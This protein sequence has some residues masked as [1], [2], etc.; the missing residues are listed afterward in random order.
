MK[1]IDV[2][3]KYVSYEIGRDI[4]SPFYATDGS[5]GMDLAACIKEPILLKPSQKETIPTGIAIQLP[6]N[7]YVALIFGRSG[8]GI[9]HGITLSNSVGVIDSDYTGEIKCGIINLGDK[10]HIINPGDRIAQMIFVPIV[11]ANLIKVDELESTLRGSG[12]F[13]STGK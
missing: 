3:I 2:K 10:E 6:S 7:N 11:L 5:A 4:T 8:L 12:G 1:K 9:K 13:G